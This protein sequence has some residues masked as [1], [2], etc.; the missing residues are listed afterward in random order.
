MAVSVK[1]DGVE[2]NG[3]DG[4]RLHGQIT[5]SRSALE[6]REIVVAGL[7]TGS[8]VTDLQTKWETAKSVCNTINKSA[9]VS[10]DSAATNFLEEFFLS[11]GKTTKIETYISGDI[12]RI[13]T[14]TTM[15]FVL[16]IRVSEY[17]ATPTGGNAGVTPRYQG[18]VGDWRL[19]TIYNEARV[20]SR[21]LTI[22]FATLFDDDAYGPF[23]ISSVEDVG[24]K[25]RF[26]V[27]TAPP[28]YTVGMKLF[29]SGST[30]Y[31]QTH[32]VTAVDVGNKKVTVDTAYAGNDTGTAL[33][34]EATSPQDVYDTARATLLTDVLGVGTDGTRDSTT[35]L[36]LS[37]ETVE[38][39]NDIVNVVLNA[40]WTEKS[41]DA[42]VRNLSIAVQRVELPDWP[43]VNAGPAPVSL[44]AVVTFSVDKDQAATDNPYPMWATIRASVIADILAAVNDSDAVGPIDE[45]VSYDKK[46]GVV[47]VNLSFLAKNTSIFSYSVV[48]T[49]HEELD[50]VSW[51]DS[52]GYDY[53]QHGAEP[54]TKIVAIT[55]TRVATNTSSLDVPPPEE[56]GYRY[57]IISTEQG[58]QTP[59]ERK[60]VGTVWTQSKTT[61]W[62]RFKLRSGGNPR[63]RNPVT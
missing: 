36:V 47:A 17:V 32:V 61:V 43:S 38:V 33:I 53:I 16:F 30:L 18:Q 42:D 45:A 22:S 49:V 63:V 19:M 48:T 50:Y 31:N 39:Q 24:G 60:G 55:V 20:E 57:L 26:V 59:I 10:I 41:Y 1:I 40:E 44:G 35:G 54:L 51:K 7:I 25:A 4:R 37:N 15:P 12:S 6:L 13:G 34:G 14:A 46:A 23:T 29:V 56:S 58:D 52:E 2:V 5:D 3:V 8:T 62:K 28:A 21:V 9:Q 11:D 27:T